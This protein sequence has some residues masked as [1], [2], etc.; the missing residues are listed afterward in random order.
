MHWSTEPRVTI[1]LH[2]VVVWSYLCFLWYFFL[3]TSP[4]ECATPHPP[5]PTHLQHH[6]RDPL[7]ESPEVNYVVTSR[8]TSASS[9]VMRLFRSDCRTSSSVRVCRAISSRH[10]S[11]PTT[12]TSTQA[13][14]TSRPQV[15]TWAMLTTLLCSGRYVFLSSFSLRL[16]SSYSL[17]NRLRMVTLVTDSQ[18]HARLHVIACVTQHHV[19]E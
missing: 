5:L 11:M 14:M 15:A 18:R 10:I 3:G 17:F 7:I 2:C 1:I 8:R 9:D 6:H 4:N 16:P 13:S 12:S 19:L